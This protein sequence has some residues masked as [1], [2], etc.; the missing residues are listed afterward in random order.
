MTTTQNSTTDKGEG[1]DRVHPC[2]SC[3]KPMRRIDGR[4]GPFWGCSDFPTCRATLNEVDG[5]PSA[6][7]NPD[8]RCPLCTRKLVRADKDKGEYWFCS[9]YNKGC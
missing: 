4:M 9:G 6:D 1:A 5:K 2:P 8:Y 7:I 3:K